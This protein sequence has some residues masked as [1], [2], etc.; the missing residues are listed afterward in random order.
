MIWVNDL[1][2]MANLLLMHS[3]TV[4]FF[5]CITSKLGSNRRS[6]MTNLVLKELFLA[7]QQQK[8]LSKIVWYSWR[9]YSRFHSFHRFLCYSFYRDMLRINLTYDMW[10]TLIYDVFVI[11]FVLNK[12]NW[13]CIALYFQCFYLL[14][15]CLAYGFVSE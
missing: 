8:M 13:I 9:R 7:W 12:Q 10:I 5:Q 2:T 15:I 3:V 11:I 14:H 1:K 6:I 4:N